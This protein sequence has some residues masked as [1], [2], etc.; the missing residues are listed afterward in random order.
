[1]KFKV[2]GNMLIKFVILIFF[3]YLICIQMIK[4]LTKKNKRI[5]LKIYSKKS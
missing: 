3:L 4:I 5:L 2:I 1:M